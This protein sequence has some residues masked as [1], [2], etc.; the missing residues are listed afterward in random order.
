MRLRSN[1]TRGLLGSIE[2]ATNRLGYSSVRA[3]MVRRLHHLRVPI[4]RATL[5]NQAPRKLLK[6]EKTATKAP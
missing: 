3:G 6:H 4:V 2:A 1:F 5:A